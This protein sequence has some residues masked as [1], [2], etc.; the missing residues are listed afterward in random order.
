MLN[1]AVPFTA[2]TVKLVPL[3]N[4]KITFSAA[5]LGNVTFTIPVSPTRA[6]VVIIL[7]S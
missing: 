2:L 5:F 4:V 7:N 6:S 1:T 3:G